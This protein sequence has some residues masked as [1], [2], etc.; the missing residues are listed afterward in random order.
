[1]TKGKKIFLSLCC[2][3]LFADITAIACNYLLSSNI[4]NQ[5]YVNNKLNNTIKSDDKGI[6][7]NFNSEQKSSQSIQVYQGY[8][9]N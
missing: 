4:K 5:Q 3:S 2:I 6:T 8:Q 7:I 9:S 1:M